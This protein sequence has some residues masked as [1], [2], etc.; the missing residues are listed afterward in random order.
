MAAVR[1]RPHRTDVRLVVPAA[2]RLPGHRGVPEDR[3]RRRLMAIRKQKEPN[4]AND[5]KPKDADEQ[6]GGS[7]ASRAGQ[8]LEG[9]ITQSYCSPEKAGYRCATETPGC[10]PTGFTGQCT[11]QPEVGG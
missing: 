10:E 7:P 5:E 1:L 4:M 11:K 3:G 6:Q 9:P 2:R 8:F